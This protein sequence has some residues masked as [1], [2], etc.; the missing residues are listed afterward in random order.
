M[1]NSARFWATYLTKRV[2][3]RLVLA[4]AIFFVI[5]FLIYFNPGDPAIFP[6]GS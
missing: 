4:L 6:L 5:F 1:G 2:I 3:F